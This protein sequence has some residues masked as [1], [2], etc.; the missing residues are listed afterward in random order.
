MVLGLGALASL[1][2]A[3]PTGMAFGY[4]YGYGVRAGYSAFK[5]PSSEIQKLKLS[6]DPIQGSLGAGLQSAEERTQVNLSQRGVSNMGMTTEPSITANQETMMN[7]QKSDREWISKP[8]GTIRNKKWVLQRALN[9]GIKDK[10]EAYHKFVNG[11]Y[12][13]NFTKYKSRQDRLRGGTYR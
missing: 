7:E 6:A 13:F 3:L 1:G 8:T 9:Y 10:R 11:E 5:Q 2:L 4:G 12:P